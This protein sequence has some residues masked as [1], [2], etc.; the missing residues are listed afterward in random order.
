[1]GDYM[2]LV[3]SIVSNDDASKVMKALIN[4]RYMVTK[5]ATTGGFL[6]NG[7]TTMIIGVEDH[8]V[9]DVIEII[10]KE[11]STRTKLVPNSSISDLGLY[12]SV[13]VEIKVGG[14]TIFVIDV[15]QFIKN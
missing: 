2:K 4:N 9:E 8:Q 6:M 11:S 7:N 13:P 3:L 10:K 12:A 1:M 15:E 5:L 14:S